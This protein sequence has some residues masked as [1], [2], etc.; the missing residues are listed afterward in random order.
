M[1]LFQSTR[2]DLHFYTT[3]VG[4]DTGQVGTAAVVDGAAGDAVAAVDDVADSLPAAAGEVETYFDASRHYSLL[5][6]VVQFVAGGRLRKLFV[7]DDAF[8]CTLS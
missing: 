3:G 4:K 5:L 7:V 6:P 1:I 2:R 8:H